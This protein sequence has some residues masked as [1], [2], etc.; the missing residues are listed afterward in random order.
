[1]CKVK[2]ELQ[3]YSTRKSVF[4]ENIVIC[5]TEQ[6]KVL[7]GSKVRFRYSQ[8]R[9]RF[10]YISIVLSLLQHS[11]YD[12]YNC[13]EMSLNL[14]P[15]LLIRA[16]RFRNLVRKHRVLKTTFTLKTT[17]KTP[18]KNLRKMKKKV[19]IYLYAFFK[20]LGT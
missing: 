13:K 4:F 9:F 17:K 1:M 18:T 7:A 3:I 5:K 15:C 14:F 2:S 20:C 6:C 11:L 19:F 16:V 12:K 8:K 10:S